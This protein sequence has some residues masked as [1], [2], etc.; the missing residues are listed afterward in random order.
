MKTFLIVLLLLLISSMSYAEIIKVIVKPEDGSFAERD[1]KFGQI[2]D[3]YKE[4]LD[5]TGNYKTTV[6]EYN[7]V[8]IIEYKLEEP[9]RNMYIAINNNTMRVLDNGVKWITLPKDKVSRDRLYCIAKTKNGA[10]AAA[11]VS[12]FRRHRGMR[13]EILVKDEIY[14]NKGVNGRMLIKR[15]IVPVSFYQSLNVRSNKTSIPKTASFVADNIIRLTYSDGAVEHW[16]IVLDTDDLRKNLIRHPDGDRLDEKKRALLWWNKKGNG[17]GQH[18]Q[19]KAW[20]YNED[21][22]KE[23]VYNKTPKKASASGGVSDAS[24]DPSGGFFG[25]LFASAFKFFAR[26]FAA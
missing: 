15:W 17:R 13:D 25:R 6:Y 14:S 21:A 12:T 2:P 7:D 10:V 19:F 18:E 4:Y 5:R 3:T 20:C 23:P 26:I 1:I 9:V 22:S 24:G 8:V 11:L 16:K